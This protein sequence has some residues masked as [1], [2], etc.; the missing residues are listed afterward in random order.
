M[1]DE[2]K[3]V[4]VSIGKAVKFWRKLGGF[5]QKEFS[6]RIG[7]SRSYVAK[8][9][10]GHVGVSLGRISEIAGSL[11][12]SPYTIL[13]GIPTDEELD[14]LLDIYADRSLNVTKA[15][16]EVLFCQR[17]LNGSVPI[18]YYEHILC[19]D[20]GSSYRCSTTEGIFSWANKK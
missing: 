11:G 5:D 7:T 4:L 9:E 12:V 10:N 1:K 20:R 6:D 19:I 15:E 18:E 3:I 13:R 14:T 16:M 2:G 8:L 17:F